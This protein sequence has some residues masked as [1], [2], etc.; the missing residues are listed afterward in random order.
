MLTIERVAAEARELPTLVKIGLVALLLSAFAD[1]IG[2]VDAGFAIEP[3]GHV[4]AFTPAEA[5]A[6]LAVFVSMVL[7]FIGVVVDGVGH[8]R[9]H[10]RSVA[11]DKKGVA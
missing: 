1:L 4:H 3:I 8:A 7:I 10:R 5:T 2:H 6:H 11:R 9:A